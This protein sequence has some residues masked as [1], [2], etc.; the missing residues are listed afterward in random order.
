MAQKNPKSLLTSEQIRR[1]KEESKPVVVQ[2]LDDLKRVVVPLIQDQTDDD[3][4]SF[5]C[6]IAW[7]SDD[8]RGE[9]TIRGFSKDS[10]LYRML[11]D[12]F[13][14]VK[15]QIQVQKRVEELKRDLEEM[16]EDLP[17][18]HAEV[19]DAENLT[20]NVDALIMRRLGGR[21][22]GLRVRWDLH[23]G[24]YEF[25]PFTRKLFEVEDESGQTE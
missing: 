14:A 15:K 8:E 21:R 9:D 12:G 20:F 17:N 19:W 1:L 10:S 23:E 3:P 5:D 22:K 4:V 7:S 25:D 6:K 13:E 2:C 24:S 16:G 11:I 18:Y